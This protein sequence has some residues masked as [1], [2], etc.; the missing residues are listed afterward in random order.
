MEKN[1][2]RINDY[3]AIFNL[4]PFAFERFNP[5]DRNTPDE[6]ASVRAYMKSNG[7]SVTTALPIF[8]LYALCIGFILFDGRTKQMPVGERVI[9]SFAIWI[10]AYGMLVG[11]LFEFGENNRFRLETSPAFYLLLGFS[12]PRAFT[13]LQ[14][15]LLPFKRLK[16]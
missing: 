16:F 12:I 15:T 2:A 4:D 1:F 9:C 5:L 10:I 6:K 7:F 11:N 13:L 14:N 3:A 8:L